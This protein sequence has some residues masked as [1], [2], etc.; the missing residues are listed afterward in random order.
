MPAVGESGGGG[1]TTE[2]YWRM[3]VL[4]ERAKRFWQETD[5]RVH[6]LVRELLEND[7]SSDDLEMLHVYADKLE[8]LVPL[9]ADDRYL[10]TV[11]TYEFGGGGSG[12]NIKLATVFDDARQE[13]L[14]K[15]VAE[16]DEG[17]P[18]CKL[19]GNK[20]GVTVA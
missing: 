12:E 15:A 11:L 9:I 7:W 10:R 13:R 6:A 1:R 18:S 14:R 5:G 16:C 4:R 2:A 17:A 8:E 20:D 3:S 19:F